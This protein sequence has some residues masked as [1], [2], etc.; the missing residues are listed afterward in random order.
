MMSAPAV[1]SP[2]AVAEQ[3]RGDRIPVGPVVDQ[4]TPE[5]VAGR[6][7]AIQDVEPILYPR[8]PTSIATTRTRTT[9]PRTTKRRFEVLN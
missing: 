3:A 5:R 1:S 9:T 6:G 2:V 4:D 8:E 7:D